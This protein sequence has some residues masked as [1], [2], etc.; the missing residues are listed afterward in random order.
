MPKCTCILDNDYHSPL[1][2][3]QQYRTFFKPVYQ[4]VPE[5]NMQILATNGNFFQQLATF[6]NKCNFLAVDGKIAKAFDFSTVL[7]FA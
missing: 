5:Y 7:F 2:P 4:S 3:H 1:P 6:G